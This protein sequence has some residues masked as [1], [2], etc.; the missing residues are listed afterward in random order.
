MDVRQLEYLLTIEREG[1]ISAAAEVIH[2]SQP[3]LSQ[4]L[5]KLER[6]LGMP[7]FA[8]VDK[9]MVP[10]EVGRQYLAGAREMVRIKNETY[11]RIDDLVHQKKNTISIALCPQVYQHAGHAIMQAC[12]REFDNVSFQEL[13]SDIAQDYL[14][15]DFLDGAVIS[16]TG[17][18]D[19]QLTI[20]SLYDE[21][22]LL[23]VPKDYAWEGSAIDPDA[24]RQVPFACLQESS[25]MFFLMQ[26]L[27]SDPA[28]TA[29]IN[30][31]VESLQNI[32]TLVENGYA[33]AFVPGRI[34]ED[35]RDCVL[36]HWHTRPKY[37][38]AFAYSKYSAKRKQL[39]EIQ[40]CIAEVL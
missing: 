32:R 16:Y 35:M 33:A 27:I 14:I 28:F 38:I 29:S 36:Y 34:A 19:S 23:A 1:S 13:N 4:S 2:I 11:S 9:K 17:K 8:R 18:P 31:R 22:T 5:Q 21:E 3:A 25:Y 37:E 26:P 24:L 40:A 6:Q 12:Q 15:N 20:H 7:I 39:A 30:H 10:T